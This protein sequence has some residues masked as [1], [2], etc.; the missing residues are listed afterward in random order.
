M[1]FTDLEKECL[2]SYHSHLCRKVPLTVEEK[3]D[4]DTLLTGEEDAKR[5]LVKSWIEGFEKPNVDQAVSEAD[6]HKAA[7]QAKQTELQDW[8][9]ANP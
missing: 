7:L 4:F 5:L 8:L 6:Q 3:A 9:D 1:A 2:R